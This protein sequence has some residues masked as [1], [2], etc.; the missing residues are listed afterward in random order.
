MSQ[1]IEGFV[2]TEFKTRSYARFVAECI[3]LKD[4]GYEI[5]KATS[6]RL[7]PFFWVVEYKGKFRKYFIYEDEQLVYYSKKEI[8][9]L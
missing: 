1:E 8:N 5:H 7:W 9:S 3:R 6:K 4:Q 2:K